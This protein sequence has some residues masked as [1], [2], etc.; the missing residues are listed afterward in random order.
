MAKIAAWAA[1]QGIVPAPRHARK[2]IR[3][4]GRSDR[5]IGQAPDHSGAAAQ[6]MPNCCL[7]PVP[8][9]LHDCRIVHAESVE[10][11]R[12]N[13]RRSSHAG[14]YRANRPDLRAVEEKA[15]SRRVVAASTAAGTRS[16][17]QIGPRRKRIAPPGRGGYC[18]HQSRIGGTWKNSGGPARRLGV[19]RA[20]DLTFSSLPMRVRIVN[21]RRPGC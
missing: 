13:P 21:L 8:T 20:P 5:S 2:T 4:T 19:G 11:H 12:E 18:C 15:G 16:E 1:L 7:Q 6:M 10:S 14:C 3:P 9:R 17:A